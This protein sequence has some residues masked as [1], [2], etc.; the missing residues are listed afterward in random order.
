MAQRCPCC[1][2]APLTMEPDNW[3]H[4]ANHLNT[5]PSAKTRDRA[6]EILAA[7]GLLRPD[8]PNTSVAPADTLLTWIRD[9]EHTVIHIDAAGVAT[10]AFFGVSRD[11][12]DLRRLNLGPTLLEQLQARHPGLKSF[13]GFWGLNYRVGLGTV[14]GLPMRIELVAGAA[15]LTIGNRPSIGVPC[16]VAPTR[17]EEYRILEDLL[18]GC[19]H[20]DQGAV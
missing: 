11:P 4:A 14:N 3:F 19:L 1:T 8:A 9:D 17:A 16:S 12:H 5:A 20:T 2:E 18:A 15:T 13:D 6:L 7:A 10:P